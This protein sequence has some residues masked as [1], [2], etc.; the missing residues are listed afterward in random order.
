VRALLLDSPLLFGWLP[1]TL[2]WLGV[3]SLV[4]LLVRRRRRWWTRRLWVTLG[5]TA[6]L[7]GAVWLTLRIWQPFPDALPWR[8]WLWGALGT[9][10]LVAGVVGFSL[11]RWWYRVLV[12]FAVVLVILCAAMKINVVY[13]YRPTLAGVLGVPAAYAIDFAQV[14]ASLP[15]TEP[16]PDGTVASGW[17]PP[18]DLPSGGR[19]ATVPIPGTVSGFPARPAEV[20]LPPAYLVSPRPRLPVLVLVGGQPGD[21]SDWLQA[22]ELVKIM[23]RYASEHHGL[24]P[25]VVL[26]D[27]TGS[28]FGNPLCL[29]STLGNVQTYLA[30]D[31]PAWVSTHLQASDR[32]AIGGFSYGGTC[33]LQLATNRPDVYPTFLD[34][35]GQAEPSLGDHA[36]TVA[37]AFGDRPDPEA[38][39]QA[40]NPMRRLPQVR[41]IAGRLVVGRDDHVYGPQAHRVVDS[42]QAAGLDVT[43][44]MTGGIHSWTVAKDGLV[45]E[46]PWVSRR[47]GLG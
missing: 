41:G 21:V 10:A 20:Y 22:G 2:T 42:A 11:G 47:T 36:Q 1:T 31:V 27:A 43:L 44:T 29:D 9:L 24:A 18:S 40:V 35:S 16:G 25:I 32:R 38:A 8:V 39:Y 13:A 46:L 23:D 34:M 6:V 17:T 19:V 26:P 7:L 3:V 15:L 4:F 5:T 30:E 33:A 12:P 45:A 37:A 28:S 14:P